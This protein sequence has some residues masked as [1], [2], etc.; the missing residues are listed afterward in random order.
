MSTTTECEVLL[1]LKP[2]IIISFINII[3]IMQPDKTFSNMSKVSTLVR[4]ETL[5]YDTCRLSC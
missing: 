2:I 5:P 1:S 4:E 3:I